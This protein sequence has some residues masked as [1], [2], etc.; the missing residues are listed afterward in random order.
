MNYE[1]IFNAR[2]PTIEGLA[3]PL[4]CIIRDKSGAASEATSNVA[5]WLIGKKMMWN[6][7]DK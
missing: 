1:E 5:T 4:M 7:C 2:P 6:L 3:T